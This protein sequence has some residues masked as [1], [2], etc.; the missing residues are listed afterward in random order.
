MC[1][2]FVGKVEI[3]GRREPGLEQGTTHEMVSMEGFLDAHVNHLSTRNNKFVT[4]FFFPKSKPSGPD[5]FFIRIDGCRMVPVFVQMKLHQRSFSFSEKDWSDALSIVSAPKI[6]SYVKNFREYCPDKVYISMIVAY[7][8]KWSSKLPAL[9]DLPK[10]TSGVQ[11]EM[12]N[13]GDDNFGE[14]FPKDHVEFIDRFKNVGMRSA[15][16][17]RDDDRVKK[18]RGRSYRKRQAKSK[19]AYS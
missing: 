19:A 4:P 9:P 8:T 11:Q 7:P 12:I 6:E 18:Q 14:I 15:E 1:E 13:V 17:D 5:M 3:D 16:N 10:D 2:A